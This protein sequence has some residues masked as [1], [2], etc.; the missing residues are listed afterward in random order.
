MRARFSTKWILIGLALILSLFLVLFFSRALVYLLICGMTAFLVYIRY[1]LQLPFKI[2][3]YLF[4]SVIISLGY[5]IGFTIFYVLAA[6]FIPKVIAGG[7]VDASTFLYLFFFILLNVVVTSLRIINVA[8][9]GIIAS[10]IDFLV[11]LLLGAAVKPEKIISGFVVVGINIFLF[12]N[13]GQFMLDIINL[14][15]F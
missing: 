2:E 4:F 6:M 7:D 13:A 8:T 1:S 3:P 9:I 10:V 5:G 15:V 14:K 12:I 11:I